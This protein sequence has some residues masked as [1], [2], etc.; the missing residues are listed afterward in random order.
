MLQAFFKRN[1]IFQE[2]KKKGGRVIY[3]ISGVEARRK[4]KLCLSC[5]S[6]M[7]MNGK[8]VKSRGCLASADGAKQAVKCE[9]M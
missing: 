9:A 6:G 4:R 2:F 1:T 5:C 8:G 7:W 3:A